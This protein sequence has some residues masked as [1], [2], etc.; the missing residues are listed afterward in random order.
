MVPRLESIVRLGADYRRAMY[1]NP[2]K[3]SL[4]IIFSM[5]LFTTGE[6]L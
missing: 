1:N 2:N 5:I 6:I 4:Q 3:Q